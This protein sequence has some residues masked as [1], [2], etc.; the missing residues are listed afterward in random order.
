MANRTRALLSRIARSYV[1]FVAVGVVVGLALAPVAWNATSSEGTVAV[2]PVAGTIDGSTSASVT[3][4]LQQARNDPDV[5]AVVL[6]V[7]S[8]GGGAAASEELYLQT[9]RTAAEMPLVTS[10]DAAAASGA[11]YTIAPSDRIYTKPASTVGS[12]GVLATAP[13][14]LEPTDLVATTGPNKL[15]GGDEREFNYILES[16]GN[17]FIGAV[18]EQRGDRLELTRTEVEQA[19]IYSGTQA[20]RN[21]L[22]DS[23]G[24]RQ[25]AVEHAADEAGLDNYDVR[26]MRPDG[27]ARFLSRSNYLASTAPDKEM[28]SAEYLYGEDPGGPVFLMV[29]ATYLDTANDDAD[30][31]APRTNGTERD[32][33]NRTRPA[34]AAAPGGT[35]VVA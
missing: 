15:T 5:K 22:A 12:V 6:L 32:V 25:A 24:G 10:V 33:D 30:S 4:M 2:V 20:V 27:T 19:R 14:P 11:Y 3:A 18:F 31:P 21:G 23:I 7:N 8:G 28:V 17:A 16:L 1:L 29:P 35:H 34:A 26:V 9:K 13:Q